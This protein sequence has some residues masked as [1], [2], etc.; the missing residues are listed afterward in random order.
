MTEG[1]AISNLQ[2][3][4]RRLSWTGVWKDDLQ[5]KKTRSSE[6]ETGIKSTRAIQEGS[7]A[8]MYHG[9]GGG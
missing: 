7:E 1:L 3:K 4:L 8:G 5:D 6:L 2:G 9:E